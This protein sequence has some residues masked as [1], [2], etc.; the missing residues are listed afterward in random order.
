MIAAARRHAATGHRRYGALCRF[1]AVWRAFCR[2]RKQLLS[3]QFI[4]PDNEP[5]GRLPSG[6]SR[7]TRVWPPVVQWIDHCRQT[8]SA[9][10]YPARPSEASPVGIIV[11]RFGFHFFESNFLSHGVVHHRAAGV[12]SMVMS[13][14]TGEAS[15]VCGLNRT[16][17]RNKSAGLNVYLA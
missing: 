6:R 2:D 15:L 16:R 11:H 9:R 7:A 12:L 4:A 13:A 8:Q 5:C 1:G 17:A 14:G 10:G 3:V